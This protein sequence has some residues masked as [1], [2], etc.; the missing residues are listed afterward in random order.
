VDGN[1]IL[2]SLY[3]RLGPRAV[4]IPI[5]RASKAPAQA[6]WQKRTFDET[7]RFFRQNELKDAVQRGG[8]IGVRLCDGLAA[9]DF[10]AEEWAQGFLDLN[11]IIRGSFRS[12]GARGWQVFLRMIGPYP[13][14]IHP[15]KTQ[16][17]KQ[18]GEWRGAGQ[19]VVFGKHPSGA[20]Y[21]RLVD[22]AAA[23]IA[24]DNIQWPDGLIL[25][26]KQPKPAPSVQA[27]NRV[28]TEIDAFLDRRIR[29]YMQNVDPSVAGNRGDDQLFHAACILVIGWDLTQDQALPYLRDF[30][31]RCDP[32]WPES[33]LL[34]KLSQANKQSDLRGGLRNQAP[35]WNAAPSGE[36]NRATKPTP[37]ALPYEPGCEEDPPPFA[38]KL[39]ED[40]SEPIGAPASQRPPLN[41]NCPYPPVNWSEIALQNTDAAL[42]FHHSAIFPEDSILSLYMDTGRKICEGADCYILGSILPVV[43]ALLGRRVYMHWG[44]GRIYP[45]LFNLLVGKAGDRKSSTIQLASRVALECLPQNAFLPDL[46]SPESMF[47]EFCED[48]GGRPDKLW[49]VDD[50]NPILSDWKLSSNGE[51]VGARFLTLYDCCRLT[52]SFRR[53]K[54]ETTGSRREVPET[55]TSIL[56][57]ATFNVAAFQGQQ[58]RAGIARRFLYYIADQHGRLIVRPEKRDLRPLIDSFKPLLFLKR[59]VDFDAQAFEIWEQY[60]RQNRD[61]LNAT[62]HCQD[63]LAS[64]LSS[65]PSHVQKIAILFEAC[66][67]IDHGT[68][69]TKISDRSLELAI[70][71]V[72]ENLRAAA[73]L[74]SIAIRAAI[75]QRAEVVLATVR[76]KFR[77]ARPLTIYATRSE[78][79][80]ELCKHG[81]RQGSLKTEELYDQILPALD[82]EGLAR[83]VLKQGKLEVFAFKTEEATRSA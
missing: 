20:D 68:D 80:Y 27:P 22:A 72:E 30:N 67:C 66:R 6:E 1:S 40:F 26:W 8:N 36:K 18:V 7:Q 25:P 65:A 19:S 48:A 17:G 70:K 21:Q 56:L 73:F 29:N 37:E 23:E 11:E 64:R 57:G 43:A 44:A 76:R 71:H 61:Q 60:Q 58:I 74:E 54:S 53:N 51:R 10:D 55:S 52:E 45:N 81:G 9:A 63:A 14:A 82:A 41:G 31:H 59:E 49:I 79:T 33:R 83:R 78:L 28:S 46:F 3:D 38:A 77:V 69:L 13:A 75:A 47:D 12:R 62:G 24:F 50:A 39:A 4:L 42:R 15:L 35:P 32:P 16:D 2:S 34:Y 5:P